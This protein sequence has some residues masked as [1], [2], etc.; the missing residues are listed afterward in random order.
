MATPTTLAVRAAWTTYFSTEAVGPPE[1]AIPADPFD[2]FRFR[3]LIMSKNN[4]RNVFGQ[5]AGPI[6]LAPAEARTRFPG[7]HVDCFCSAQLTVVTYIVASGARHYR[8]RCLACQRLSRTSLPQRLLNC[9][10]SAE[11][12]I[13]RGASASERGFF[14]EHCGAAGVE[15]HHWAPR[16]LFLDYNAWPTAQLC[17]ACHALW[18]HV[19]RAGSARL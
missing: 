10:T 9:A 3:K 6:T 13:V 4:E 1:K 12:P 14:C 16:S 15:T 11:A 5:A 7:H 17:H 8:L 19:M 18:R 2:L